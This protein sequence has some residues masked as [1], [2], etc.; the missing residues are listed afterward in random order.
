MDAEQQKRARHKP[1]WEHENAHSVC[2]R[3][4]RIDYTTCNRIGTLG[5]VN[6][7]CTSIAVVQKITSIT[8]FWQPLILNTV[9]CKLNFINV[10]CET[11]FKT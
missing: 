1:K 4:M 3:L 6:S 5:P 7:P 11:H 2:R 8:K 9:K 10:N